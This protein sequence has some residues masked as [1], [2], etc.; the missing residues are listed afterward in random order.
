[1]SAALLWSAR[2]V[3]RVTV[4]CDLIDEATK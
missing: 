4:V 2:Q 1:M 3:K